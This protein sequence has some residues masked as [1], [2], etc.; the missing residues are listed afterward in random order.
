[1]KYIATTEK[2]WELLKSN[3]T[4][5]TKVIATDGDYKDTVIDKNIF[6]ENMEFLMESGCFVNCIGWHYEKPYSG[7]DVSKQEWVLTTGKMNG[8]IE[9]SLTVHIQK[10]SIVPESV[11]KKKEDIAKLENLSSEYKEFFDT[12]TSFRRVELNA[13]TTAQILEII[14]NKLSNVNNLPTINLEETLSI[15]H[16]A[17]K[18]TA[19]MRLVSEKYKKQLSDIYVPIDLS[20]YT[21]KYTVKAAKN[22]IPELE[23][24][25]IQQYQEVIANKL[26]I[27]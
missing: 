24:Q 17:I 4:E 1:M 8:E 13:F 20:E 5:I 15:D 10:Y 22:E 27:S 3:T 25:I 14:D 26:N 11:E 19:F 18:E 6:M 2:V 12:G 21:A 7:E 23:E 16:N 9:N